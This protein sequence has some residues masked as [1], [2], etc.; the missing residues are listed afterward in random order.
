MADRRGPLLPLPV[1]PG[2]PRADLPRARRGADDRRTV[3]PLR[4][5][6]GTDVRGV[7]RRERTGHPDLSDHSVRRR[8]SAVQL[9]EDLV[10]VLGVAPAVVG[11]ERVVGRLRL[12]DDRWR[13]ELYFAVAGDRA[14]Q[15]DQ[16]EERALELGAHARSTSA[17]SRRASA[18]TS[19]GSTG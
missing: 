10:Q 6:T 15:L 1:R 5:A 16:G 17:E 19:A 2:G 13:A 3:R 12:G 11:A 14:Q 18:T 9:V 8:R 7:R 4:P